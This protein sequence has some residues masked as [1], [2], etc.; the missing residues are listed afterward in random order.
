MSDETLTITDDDQKA[1]PET[2]T[3]AEIPT[4]ELSNEG[5][6]AAEAVPGHD[7]QPTQS[8]NQLDVMKKVNAELL[9]ANQDLQE[10]VKRTSAEFQ[11]FRRRQEEEAK[12]VKV[13][14]REDIIRSMLPILDHLERTLAA[15]K[16]GDGSLD[17]LIQGVELIDKDVKKI[18][19]EH[20]LSPIKA[21]GEIFDAALHQAVMREETNDVPDQTV[22]AELQR[23]YKLEDRVIRPSMVQVAV[24]FE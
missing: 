14:L 12:R 13:R 24:N 9:R 23:G 11:N 5:L 19:S 1:A 20:G 2:A 3:Q 22:M 16:Q 7:D 21:Y 15:V 6:T 18:F 17:T 10:Q 8:V 4:A